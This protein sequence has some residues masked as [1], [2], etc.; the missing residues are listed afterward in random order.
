LEEK[1]RFDLSEKGVDNFGD[2]E[3]IAEPK[4]TFT[5]EKRDGG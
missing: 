3:A 4:S 5:Q 1:D 2:A